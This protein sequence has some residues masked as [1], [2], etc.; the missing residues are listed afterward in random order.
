MA[1]E[2]MDMMQ[3]LQ[4]M[5][6]T[7]RDIQTRLGGV[8]IRLGS[9]ETGKDRL[10]STVDKMAVRVAVIESTMATKLATKEDF[11]EARA[12][13]ESM[14]ARIVEASEIA[15]DAGRKILSGPAILKQVRGELDDHEIRLRH[16]EEK[17]RRG[18]A[19]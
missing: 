1:G 12:Y 13:G 19:A 17:G 3:I 5:R 16:L 6:Q 10:Q 4:E 9:L 15:R 14:L 11:A 18:P 8:E 2:D 7:L